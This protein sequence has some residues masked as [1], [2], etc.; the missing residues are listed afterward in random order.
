MFN[1]PQIFFEFYD[2]ENNCS[3][4]FVGGPDRYDSTKHQLFALTAQEYN[5]KYMTTF[6]ALKTI[7]YPDNTPAF[8]IGEFQ[9]ITR[10]IQ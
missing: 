3:N 1:Q 5:E 7:F 4:C 10:S 9:N 8:Y 6:K 2:P